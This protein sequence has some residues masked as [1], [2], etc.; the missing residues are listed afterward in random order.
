MGH[1]SLELVV[2]TTFVVTAA[3][4]VLGFIGYGGWPTGEQDGSLS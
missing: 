2:W 3:A 1:L 4:S